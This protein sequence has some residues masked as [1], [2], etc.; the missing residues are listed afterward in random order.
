MWPFKHIIFLF[1]A[2]L[3]LGSV[4]SATDIKRLIAYECVLEKYDKR[5]AIISVTI[6]TSQGRSDSPD[7][8]I[9]RAD[10][11]VVI[12]DLD[13]KNR[14]YPSEEGNFETSEGGVRIA[15]NFA[16]SM[17]VVLTYKVTSR[18]G[19]LSR[20]P[21]P[22][23]LIMPNVGGASVHIVLHLSPTDAIFGDIF[24]S[25]K[26]IG[27]GEWRAELTNVPSIILFQSKTRLHISWRERFLTKAWLADFGIII[28]AISSITILYLRYSSRSTIAEEPWA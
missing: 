17:P 12:T 3:G 22:V 2:L 24:P 25:F 9:L 26:E 28:F 27:P 13:L 5:T 18:D 23:P 11:R 20:F 7:A 19:E 1:V 15:T 21:L 10:K 6:S 14:G 16:N 8:I 4:S